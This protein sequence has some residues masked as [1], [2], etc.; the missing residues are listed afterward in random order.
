MVAYLPLGTR[1][2]IGVVLGVSLVGKVRVRA[3]IATFAASIGG[4]RLVPGR[5]AR[6][7]ATA[8]LVTEVAVCGL[9]AVPMTYQ[10]GLGLGVA[11]MSMYAVVVGSVMRKGVRA[12]CGCFGSSDERPLG[13]PQLVRNLL[14]VGI[15]ALGLLTSAD[16]PANLHTA[17][18]A[19]VVAAA[20]LLAMVVV[21][22]DDIVDL[23]APLPPRPG[24]EPSPATR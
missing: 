4:L 3:P 23:F 24:R 12:P 7:V 8:V 13:Y 21:R 9:L 2:V 5:A 20:V 19:I 15:G 14:L 11:L 10:L 17:G 16:P 22:L 1:I 18:V 6:A